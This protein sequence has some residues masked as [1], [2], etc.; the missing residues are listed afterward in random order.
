MILFNS[1]EM[2][3]CMKKGYY[4]NFVSTEDASD[5]KP[6]GVVQREWV[7]WGMSLLSKWPGIS[8]L[9]YTVS[10]RN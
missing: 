4:N 3:M 5:P 10:R 6:M 9:Q 7:N 2:D 8:K 1:L